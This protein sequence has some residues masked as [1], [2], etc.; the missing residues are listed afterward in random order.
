M[1]TRKPFILLISGTSGSGKTTIYELLKKDSSLKHINFHD[2]DENGV[3]QVGRGAWR[4]FRIEELYYNA[5]EKLKTNQS[6]I[7]CGISMPHEIIESRYYK[8]NHPVHFLLL[9]TP[10]TVIR[11]RLKQ[12]VDEQAKKG[13]YDE[14]FSK[15]SWN[16]LIRGNKILKRRLTHSTINQKR[17]YIVNTARL[18]RETMYKQVKS[19]IND[20]DDFTEAKKGAE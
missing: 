16:E 10:F 12:R 7:I 8:T 3:P 2:I 15:S 9:E 18:S 20:I 5:A 1:A 17:G 13:T 11:Q 4:K 14:S 6:S 19:L